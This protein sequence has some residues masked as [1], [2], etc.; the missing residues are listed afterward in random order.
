MHSDS[1]GAPCCWFLKPQFFTLCL[2]DLIHGAVPQ[3]AHQLQYNQERMKYSGEEFLPATRHDRPP[4]P[5]FSR[6]WC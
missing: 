4:C 6:C 5:A 1:P 2:I 3:L